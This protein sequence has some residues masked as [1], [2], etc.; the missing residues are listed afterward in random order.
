[1]DANITWGHRNQRA[2]N[3]RQNSFVRHSILVVLGLL[4]NL[5]DVTGISATHGFFECLIQGHDL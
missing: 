4:N 5:A 3:I 1:M 2:K